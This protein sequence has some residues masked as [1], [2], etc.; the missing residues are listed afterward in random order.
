M[1]HC[2]KT[3]LTQNSYSEDNDGPE[4]LHALR[5]IPNLFYFK[6]A[7]KSDN[8]IQSYAPKT[9]LQVI[10]SFGPSGRPETPPTDITLR[11]KLD[12][13]KHS[14][15]TSHVYRLKLRGSAAPTLKINK[16]EGRNRGKTLNF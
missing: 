7:L 12:K 14:S 8:T 4:L 2:T 3:F 9:D 15:S 6:F 1:V 10:K 5:Y 16:I 11:G 13:S